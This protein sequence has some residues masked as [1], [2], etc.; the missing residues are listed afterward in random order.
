M[1]KTSTRREHLLGRM[2]AGIERFLARKRPEDLLP[3]VPQERPMPSVERVFEI[4]G[5]A[6]RNHGGP[7][8]GS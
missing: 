7:A 8:K 3:P 1:I 2:K 5:D 4:L 6:H